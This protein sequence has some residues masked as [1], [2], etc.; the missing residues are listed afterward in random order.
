MAF[1]C[2]TIV[3]K[4]DVIGFLFYKIG[5]KIQVT[6]FQDLGFLF[7]FTCL[8]TLCDR[9][10]KYLNQC[11]RLLIGRTNSRIPRISFK[12]RMFQLSSRYFVYMSISRGVLLYLF[13]LSLLFN[14]TVVIVL[15]GIQPI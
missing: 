5:L 14:G 2:V 6:I 7:V 11:L 1:F 9:F 4:P 12:S 10:R 8:I 3:T 15:I 13:A